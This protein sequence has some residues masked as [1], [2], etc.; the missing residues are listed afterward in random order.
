MIIF[1]YGVNR[2]V[3]NSRSTRGSGGI[4]LLVRKDLHDLCT[5]SKCCEFDDYM[6][7]LHFN[8]RKSDCMFIVVCIFAT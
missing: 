6:L 2:A 3:E 8:D 4:G 7:G 1:F 5:I